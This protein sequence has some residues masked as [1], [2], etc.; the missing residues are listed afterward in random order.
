MAVVILFTTL[1]YMELLFVTKYFLDADMYS[2]DTN[3]QGF[4][5]NTNRNIYALSIQFW[6]LIA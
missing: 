1:H 6:L 5:D 2:Q 4:Q 3:T